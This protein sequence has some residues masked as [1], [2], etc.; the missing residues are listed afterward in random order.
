MG[1]PAIRDHQRNPRKIL[2]LRMLGH[3]EL[4]QLARLAVQDARRKTSSSDT[5]YEVFSAIFAAFCKIWAERE[6]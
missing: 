3:T 5:Q 4:A 6:K 1:C 2:T